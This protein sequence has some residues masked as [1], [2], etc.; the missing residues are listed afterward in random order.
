MKVLVLFYAVAVSLDRL[1]AGILVLLKIS[2][3][4]GPCLYFPK[5]QKVSGTV[6]Y[7][8]QV[9]PFC[10]WDFFIHVSVYQIEIN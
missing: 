8:L 10:F 5:H 4:S 7:K 9:T 6:E 2:G 1:F 3:V